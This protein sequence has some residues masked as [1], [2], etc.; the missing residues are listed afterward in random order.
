MDGTQMN[1]RLPPLADE[2]V[3]ALRTHGAEL[4]GAGIRHLS[5]FGSV[6]RGDAR[7]KSDVDLAVDL[8]PAAHVGLFRLMGLQRRLSEIL[9]RPVDLLPE[10]VENPRLQERIDRDRCRAF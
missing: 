3:S 4:R 2:I 10:P 6:A 8:D 9:N 7:G 1:D 5:V